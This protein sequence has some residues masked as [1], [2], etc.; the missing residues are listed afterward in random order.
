[1]GSPPSAYTADEDSDDAMAPSLSWLLHTLSEE[2]RAAFDAALAQVLGEGVDLDVEVDV[3]LAD[4]DWR[5]ALMSI[6]ARL[7]DVE[8]AGAI[9][10]VLDI[11]DSARARKELERRATFDSLT[12][13]HNRSS[14]L[15][16]LERELSSPRREELAVL[17]VDLDRFKQINDTLGH[18]AGDD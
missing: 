9:T 8:V 5:R 2:G 16:A 18:A 1:D 3:V 10:C 15:S 6:R 13:C 11:T 12:N 7:R 17:Y 4:G 14:I